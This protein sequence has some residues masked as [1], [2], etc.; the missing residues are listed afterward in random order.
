[1]KKFYFYLLILFFAPYLYGEELVVPKEEELKKITIG[2][3]DNLNGIRANNSPWV[4]YTSTVFLAPHIMLL[5]LENQNQMHLLPRGEKFDTKDPILN[6]LDQLAYLS[7]ENN[8]RGDICFGQISNIGFTKTNCL[9]NLIN[10]DLAK[11][12]FSQ[13]FWAKDNEI[14]FVSTDSMGYESENKI[15]I[16]NLNKNQFKIITKGNYSSPR[17]HPDG[18]HLVMIERHHQ[19]SNSQILGLVV[20]DI[21]KNQFHKIELNLPGISAHPNFSAKGNE[22]YFTHYLFD[23]LG[24]GIIDAHDNGII[25]KL[26]WELIIEQK[27]SKKPLFPLQLTSGEINCSLPHA[28]KDQIIYMSCSDHQSLDIYSMPITGTIPKNWTQT[29]FDYA[30]RSARSAQSRIFYYNTLISRKN[31]EFD[32]EMLQ[33]LVSNYLQLKTPSTVHFFLENLIKNTKDF[34]LRQYYFSLLME[35][36]K[37]KDK[38]PKKFKYALMYYFYMEH[39][40][41]LKI[42]NIKLVPLSYPIWNSSLVSEETKLY[43]AQFV[44]KTL[45]ISTIQEIIEKLEKEENAKVVY[46]FFT[47]LSLIHQIAQTKDPKDAQQIYNKLSKFFNEHYKNYFLRRNLAIMAI[48]IFKENDLPKFR[49]FVSLLWTRYT[50]REDTEYSLALEQFT[51]NSLDLAYRSPQPSGVFYQTLLLS[52][53]Q[54]AHYGYITNQNDELLLKNSYKDLVDRSITHVNFHLL[55]FIKK[56]NDTSTQMDELFKAFEP[57]KNEHQ[58]VLVDFFQGVLYLM[59]LLNQKNLSSLERNEIGNKAHHHFILSLEHAKY[60]KRPL[61]SILSNLGLLHYKLKNYG[62]AIKYFEQ[63][64]NIKEKYLHKEDEIKDFLLKLYYAQAQYYSQ[65]YR[66]CIQTFEEIL[67]LMPTYIKNTKV[68]FYYHSKLALAYMALQ[69]Y[70]KALNIYETIFDSKLV[71]SNY[72]LSY[73]YLLFKLHQHSSSKIVLQHPL[74]DKDDNSRRQSIRF[75]L[76]ARLSKNDAISRESYLQQQTQHLIF[77]LENPK[78]YPHSKEFVLEA[79]SKNFFLNNQFAK[80]LEFTKKWLDET[81]NFMSTGLYQV[82]KYL[83]KNKLQNDESKLVLNRYKNLLHKIASSSEDAK[84]LVDKRLQDLLLGTF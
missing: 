11:D 31:L 29:Q 48:E 52:D 5:N 60:R 58:E 77:I 49:D 21:N 46:L 75:G 69:D 83:K 59:K 24:D 55:N 51:M 43:Q 68:N 17:M 57:L 15:V 72:L 32:E 71:N 40:N 19:N 14:G 67:P 53:D 82:M 81:S 37:F 56:L 1:M 54:E 65:N 78:T 9:R 74:L 12:E 84:K 63:R 4:I 35:P 61:A 62:L 34:H 27:K 80:G 39:I 6:S 33:K 28:Y 42:P 8:A 22:L 73:A 10:N 13:V 18:Q 66:I 47:G 41:Q 16:F 64:M 45:T 79:I 38:D 25:M 30:I 20:M 23:T 44:S 70:K 76:L 26:D 7:Y 2:P 3:H 36:N 50:Q